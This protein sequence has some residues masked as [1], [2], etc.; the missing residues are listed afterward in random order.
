MPRERRPRLRATRSETPAGELLLPH[1]VLSRLSTVTQLEV[2][3]VSAGPW[4]CPRL[5]MIAFNKRGAACALPQPSVSPPIVTFLASA[6]LQDLVWL[7]PMSPS[8]S[9]AVPLLRSEPRR[10]RLMRLLPVGLSSPC[11]LKF[12]SLAWAPVT[13]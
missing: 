2:I 3:R 4:S 7:A 11:N 8:H 13:G 1:A 6:P 10:F 5:W 9:N 12:E